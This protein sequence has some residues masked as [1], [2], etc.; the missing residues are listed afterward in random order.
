M[1][2]PFD[3]PT[4]EV[5]AGS[6]RGGKVAPKHHA[7]RFVLVPHLRAEPEVKTPAYRGPGRTRERGP[8]I[9]ATVP[10]ATT[11]PT[12]VGYARHRTAQQAPGP[13]RRG[14]SPAVLRMNRS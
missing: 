4:C 13:V 10:Q 9:D 11:K 7:P 14:T 1:N 6:S 2:E 12:G 5:P 8:A 3:R